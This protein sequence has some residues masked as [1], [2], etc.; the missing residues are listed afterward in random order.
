MSSITGL[1]PLK[2]TSLTNTG[3]IA[4]NT[5]LNQ[6]TTGQVIKSNGPGVPV[7]WENETIHPAQEPLNK[8]NNVTFSSGATF[9]DGSVAETI[10][11]MLVLV[12]S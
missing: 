10:N 4:L 11:M 6:G 9:Y 7:S 1:R 2:G 8:G 3:F 5:T 12:F